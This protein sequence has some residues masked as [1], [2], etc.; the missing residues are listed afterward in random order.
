MP[1]C[2]KYFHKPQYE[3]KSLIT[4]DSPLPLGES[5]KKKITILNQNKPW[6]QTNSNKMYAEI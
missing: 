1:I 2:L 4:N 3:Q 6:L 5:P